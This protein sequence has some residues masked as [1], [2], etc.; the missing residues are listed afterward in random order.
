MRWY[1]EAIKR[2]LGFINGHPLARKHLLRAYFRFFIWQVKLRL[3]KD[4]QK[5]RFIGNTHFLAKKGLTGITGNIYA[6]LHEFPDMSFLIHFLTPED[7]FFD[8][9]ANVG[10]YTIL[11]SGV[12]GA[13]S[14]SFEP[15][16]ETFNILKKNV[17]SN[18][19]THLVKTE[20][21]GVGGQSAMLKF[22]AKEDTTNHVIAFDENESNYV[23]VPVTDLNSFYPEYKPAL[24][25]I[26]VEGFETEVLNG[27]DSL[28]DDDRLKAIIIE[29]NG[30]GLR[31]GFSDR[32]IHTKLASKNF[33]PYSYNPFNRYLEEMETF[34]KFNTIYIRDIESVIIKIK[35]A[36]S[37]KVFNEII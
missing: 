4:L 7:V 11:A 12:C 30:S 14:L 23:E 18:R 34:G 28:L 10:S 26:D 37:F 8:V 27:G 15:V 20:N 1:V 5:V 35:K 33:K 13:R 19:L 9:G 3:N 36:K 31:Y 21:R 16:P 32:D 29:L 17:E 24:I 6:G 2:T 22:S 25:K